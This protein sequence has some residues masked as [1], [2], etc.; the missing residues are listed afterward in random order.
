MCVGE[1]IFILFASFSQLLTGAWQPN[2][3]ALLH[4]ELGISQA[5]ASQ[6]LMRRAEFRDPRLL[7]EHDAKVVAT[8]KSL[9]FPFE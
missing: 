7:N 6:Q 5:Q 8:L 4:T 1:L 9:L 2:W 3:A